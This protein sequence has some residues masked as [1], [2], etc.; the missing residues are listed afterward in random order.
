M[1]SCPDSWRFIVRPPPLKVRAVSH[2]FHGCGW[3]TVPWVLPRVWVS[4]IERAVV[5]FGSNA[6]GRSN[7]L[8][9]R[10]GKP[11]SPF[12]VRLSLG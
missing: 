9:I 2:G 10:D 3:P 7:P 4:A 11:G 8:S 12:E 6:F 1:A 5:H